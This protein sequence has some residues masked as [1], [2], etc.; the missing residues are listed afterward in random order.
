VD[1]GRADGRMFLV[2]LGC[3][4]DAEVVRQVHA[5]RE[6]ASRRGGHIGYLSYIKPIFRSIRNYHYPEIR[7]YCDPGGEDSSDPDAS[8]LRGRWAFA[9]NL[10]RYG[11]GLPL[12][13]G[14]TGRD[15]ALDVCTFARG[16]L[17]SGL[18]YAAAAQL[19]GQH[20]RLSDCRMDKARRVRF[21]ADEPVAYQLDGDPGGL[22]PVEA[23]ILPGRVT[24]VVSRREAAKHGLG[25]P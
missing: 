25:E 20:R 2:M 23:E 4:F 7:V 22:L 8:P 24:L 13:P 21:V 6:E 18:K 1:A 5:Q 16:S 19:G 17:L 15:G 14:A 3:G 12:A 10:P 11:W 9:F